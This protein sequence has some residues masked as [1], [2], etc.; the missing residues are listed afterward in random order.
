VTDTEGNVVS[1]LVVTALSY[2]EA[3]CVGWWIYSFNVIAIVDCAL[4]AA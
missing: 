2:I 4:I 3:G 1:L